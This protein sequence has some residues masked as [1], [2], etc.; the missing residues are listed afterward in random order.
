MRTSPDGIAW[1]KERESLRLVA[2]QDAGRDL[3]RRLRP[4]WSR[5]PQGPDDHRG[6]SRRAAGSGSCPLRSR[7][8]RASE[9]ATDAVQEFDALVSFAFNCGE[10]ALDPKECTAVRML[11]A[12]SRRSFARNLVRW[13]KVKDVYDEGLA[14]RRADEIYQFAGGRR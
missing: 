7:S 2:Y 9:G 4:Y 12:G 14:M 6:A 11:N 5:G 8:S 10:G 1:L 3:D 13:N